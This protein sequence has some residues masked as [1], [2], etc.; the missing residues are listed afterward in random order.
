KRKLNANEDKYLDDV[1]NLEA[2]LKKNENV[3][4]NDQLLKATLKHDVTCFDSMNDDLTAEIEKVKREYKDVLGYDLNLFFSYLISLS[5]AREEHSYSPRNELLFSDLSSF[6]LKT[7][8]DEVIPF[9]KQSNDLKKKLVKNNEAEMVIYNA[10][11]R[12]EYERIFMYKTEKE[13]WKTLI[14]THQDESID[15]ALAR[16]NTIITSLKALDEESKNLM[17]LSLDELIGNLK[18]HKM[19]IKKDPEIV[20]AKVKRKSLAL[21]AKKESSDEECSTSIS[22]DEEY[23]MAV[24]D[25][26]KFFKRRGRFV[27]QHQNDKKTFQR[28]CDDKNG[29]SDRN[30]L[31]ADIRIILLE[32]I[33]SHQKMRTKGRLSKVL[34]VISVKKM[35][36]RSKTKR[37]S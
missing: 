14:I 31:D 21:K 26:K 27:R 33:Q 25:F 11:P 9:D 28:S 37:V 12:Q 30:D 15:T 23:A 20:K 34:G 2:K 22:E 6:L 4:L 36:R 13:I 10:L 5:G 32:N 18:V 17:S 29:K 16:F 7:K 24:R 8:L 35:L 1:L 3:I 19:I